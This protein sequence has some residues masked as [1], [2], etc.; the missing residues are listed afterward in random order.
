M[1]KKTIK[2]MAVA[3]AVTLAGVNAYKASK[4]VPEK[5]KWE[6]LPEVNVDVEKFARDLSDAIKIKTISHLDDNLTD[7][8]EFDKFHAF[9]EER[10]P[11]IHSTLEK[12]V[13]GK[14]SLMFRWKGSKEGL[15]PVALLSHQD[16]V[17]VSKGT[18]DDWEHPAFEGYNDGEYIWGRGA[19]DMKNHLI[20]VCEA[21]ESLIAEGFTPERDV[22]LLFGHNEEV[23]AEDERNGALLMCRTLKARGIH[24]DCLI[25]EGGAIIPVKIPGVMDKEVCGIG[26]AE[27]GHVDFEISI[28]G[29]GGHSSQAPKHNALGELSYV[30]QDLENHQFKA[31]LTPMMKG[32][33]DTVGRNCSFAVRQIMC[34]YKLLSPALVAVMQNIPAAASMIRTTTA[35]TMA[36]GSPAANV[37]PQKASIVAN[38][39]IMPGQTMDDVERHIRKVVKNKKAEIV[40]LKG[41][42]PSA[43]SPTDSRCFKIIEDISSRMNTNSV[44]APYLVMGGTD[45]RNY[46]EV[47]ENCY[48]YSPFKAGPSLLLTCHGTNERIP[49]SC[50]ANAVEFFKH[51][52]TAVSEE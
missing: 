23:M 18:E 51:Y 20:G 44:V 26:V 37:L 4:F 42:N 12:E 6:P 2:R 19:L 39:R 28:P 21:V 27:K 31:E 24:L 46:E 41:G 50:F 5:K 14:A 43:I 3:G 36:N 7:W 22:Y 45:A 17:P 10:F 30:I 33:I 16:V 48:R 34:N 29:K 1:E 9:L 25:D 47:C 52:I 15:D 8:A 38:F 35:V 11:L 32:L 49:I 40:R 13:I